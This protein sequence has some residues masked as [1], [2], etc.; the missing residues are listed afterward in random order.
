M[1]KRT[2]LLIA[3][4]ATSNVALAAPPV[5]SYD[6]LEQR[7]EAATAPLSIR[8]L[9]GTYMGICFPHD[10][11]SKSFEV[12]L[13][14]VDRHQGENEGPA[15]S[16]QPSYKMAM[17]PP[18]ALIDLTR[19]DFIENDSITQDEKLINQDQINEFWQVWSNSVSSLDDNS[20][21]E[22]SVSNLAFA[23]NVATS[24]VVDEKDPPNE[25]AQKDVTIY[26]VKKGADGYL[27]G[28]WT[29]PQWQ[30]GDADIDGG[31]GEDDYC[32]FFKK[33]NPSEK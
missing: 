31:P 10:Q 18:Y 5:G 8:D 22:R 30:W 4:L 23:E 12:V 29:S 27:Y 7:Y 16:H 25:P 26:S 15:F 33:L 17:V 11:R 32:Y 21:A 9:L 1:K 24:T 2:L 6:E 19:P 20:T 28:K 3:S 13:T 14:T